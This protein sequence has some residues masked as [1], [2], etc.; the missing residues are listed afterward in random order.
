M[1]LYLIVVF[2]LFLS[3]KKN[4]DKPVI[5][6]PTDLTTEIIVN[7]SIVSAHVQA[8]NANF[9]TI[10]FYQGT[11]STV[12]ETTDGI[13]NHTYTASGTYIIRSKAHTTYEDFIQKIDTVIIN[14]G[15]GTS[16]PPLLGY[17]TPLSYAGYTLVWNDEFDGTLLSS[18]WA[19]DI[20]SGSGGWGNNELQ[21]Y[22]N[23]NATVSNGILEIKAK[24]ETINSQQYTSSRIKTQ[25][26]NSW[27]YGRIDI[28][29]AL[30]KGKGI[31]PALW[32]LGDNIST[33]GW[34]N[35]GEIDIMEM[36]G[37]AGYNDKTV[38]GTAHWDDNGTHAQFGDNYS[39]LSGDFSDEF[40][41]FSIIWDANSIKWLVDDVQYNILDITPA[42][43]TEFQQN[44]FLIFN[45]AVGGNW[46]GSPD[47]TTSFPQSMYVDYVRVFQ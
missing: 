11:D 29:A 19:Y 36:I 9:Y 18:D 25:S 12:V 42:Q 10:T 39:L 5:T 24:V 23:Q 7:A 2:P 47:G 3:C 17:S 4:N 40:H 43:L 35:C 15:Q 31:W 34:P 6:L 14:L 46:P 33:A 8:V 26:I 22:T 21:Y 32:M 45:V 16:G 41:V 28:R 38:Y 20:G 27:K 30:P 44:F 37:G 1:K 13:A